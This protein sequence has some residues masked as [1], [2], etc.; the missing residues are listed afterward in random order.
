[1][2]EENQKLQVLDAHGLQL[3]VGKLKDGTLI[4]GKAGSVDAADI[5]GTIPLN[6]IPA[7]ALE[8]ITIVETDAA[9]LAL[10]SEQVQNGDSVKVTETGLMYAVVDDTKLGTADAAEAFTEYVVGTAAK[11]ALA[12]AVPWSGITDKPESFTPSAHAHT[13]SEV[14]VEAIPDATIEAIIS[15]TWNPNS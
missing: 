10:T 7:A 15:G 14:G 13:P 3:F 2:A 1:M 11:A 8:R 5:N 4:V 6:K 9:R 12:E